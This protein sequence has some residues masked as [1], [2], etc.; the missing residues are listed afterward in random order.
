MSRGNV[1]ALR[2]IYGSLERGDPS[3]FWALLRTLVEQDRSSE[4]R[5]GL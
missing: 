4:R 2:E 1:D 5:T 3:L